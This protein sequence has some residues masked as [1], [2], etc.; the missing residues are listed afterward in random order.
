MVREAAKSRLKLLA[1]TA[2]AL[3]K[4]SDA[5]TAELKEIEADLNALQIGLE[6]FL[7][8]EN[9]AE[10]DIEEEWI[11]DGRC[12]DGGYNQQYFHAWHLGYG[13]DGDEWGLLVRKYKTIPRDYPAQDDVTLVSQTR[14]VHASRELRLAAAEQ[15]IKLLDLIE[16]QAKEKIAAVQKMLDRDSK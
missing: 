5:F 3:N 4:A 7:Q 1:K 10:S 13:R 9:I 8:R 6:V 16:E 12:D 15:I 14:L 11:E 2:D